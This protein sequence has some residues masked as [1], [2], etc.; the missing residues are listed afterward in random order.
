MIQ[1]TNKKAQVGIKF[2]EK[3]YVSKKCQ[4]RY[5]EKDYIIHR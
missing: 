3:D 1:T 5:N 4:Q 2:K